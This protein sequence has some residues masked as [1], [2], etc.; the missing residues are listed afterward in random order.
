[1][2]CSKT[3][4]CAWVPK[5]TCLKFGLAGIPFREGTVAVVDAYD[6][7]SMLS[8]AMPTRGPEYILNVDKIEFHN[9]PN[10]YMDHV[11]AITGALSV[12]HEGNLYRIRL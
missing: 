5:V 7:D 3:I 10:T 11:I 9:D 4:S 6:A 8:S 1:M 2:H 12:V